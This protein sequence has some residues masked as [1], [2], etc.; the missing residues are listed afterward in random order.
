[1]RHVVLA[2]ALAGCYE[3]SRGVDE[4]TLC[5]GY[6]AHARHE[7]PLRLL[8][9]Y[10]RGDGF[11]PVVQAMERINDAP[12]VDGRACLRLRP[13]S[14]GLLAG[15]DSNI[16]LVE[17]RFARGE[18]APR[19]K[20]WPIELI[21]YEDRNES[22]GLEAANAGDPR[23]DEVVWRLGTSRSERLV[24]LW[25]RDLEEQVGGLEADELESI[26]PHL[27]PGNR[28]FVLVSEESS[29]L[30]WPGY[31]VISPAEPVAGSV[32]RG[33]TPWIEVPVGGEALDEPRCNPTA[34]FPG[35]LAWNH[36]SVDGEASV[37]VD[38]RIP[39]D[40]V[41][42]EA[43]EPFDG[44]LPPAFWYCLRSGPHLLAFTERPLWKVGPEDCLC[45]RV[46]NVTRVL[47]LADDPPPWLVCGVS[48]EEA[49]LS[50]YF[51]PRPW[52]AP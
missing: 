39:A 8:A 19:F 32:G 41:L 34:L 1:M 20:A 12:M 21:L 44:P 37:R 33:P 17:L 45:V 16:D 3:T 2:L 40:E 15:A 25:I 26:Y 47:T 48:P 13:P 31:Q 42:V 36:D 38:P 9:L 22:N 23:S 18:H 49:D 46:E 51:A 27:A 5:V 29:I 52:W 28:P 4:A 50:R 43:T 30:V 11:S 6:E 24:P 35:C 10:Q 14:A 7:A